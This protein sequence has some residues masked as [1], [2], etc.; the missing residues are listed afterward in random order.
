M[1][2]LSGEPGIGKSRLTAALEN[3]LK[4][5]AHICLRYFCQ[6]HH[7][8]SAL[9][10]VLAQLA[11]AADFAFDDPPPA[12]RSKLEKLLAPERRRGLVPF[13]ELL[14]IANGKAG[15]RHG[16]AAHAARRAR[17]H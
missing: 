2:L 17:R 8:G 4:G 1:V 13:A 7:Q 11:H 10:P 9:Q 5:D 6:P 14:G 3:G 15:R 12:R 16:P